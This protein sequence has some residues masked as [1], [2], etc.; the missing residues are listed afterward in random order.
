MQPNVCRRKI[1][2]KLIDDRFEELVADLKYMLSFRTDAHCM[3]QRKMI[4]LGVP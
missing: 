3:N 1:M 2:H 4:R